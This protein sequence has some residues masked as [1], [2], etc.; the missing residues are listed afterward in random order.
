MFTLGIYAL[1]FSRIATVSER[2]WPLI[3][4][5]ITHRSFQNLDELEEVLFQPCQVLLKQ[6]SVIKGITCFHWWP[7]TK[8][9]SFRCNRN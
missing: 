4:E 7:E 5:P 9:I 8:A 2:L 1:S 3:N 6:S